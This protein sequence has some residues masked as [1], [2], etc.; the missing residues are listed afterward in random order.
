MLPVRRYLVTGSWTLAFVLTT[1]MAS[2]SCAVAPG[3]TIPL[4]TNGFG[5]FSLLV[6]D[7]TGLVAGAEAHEQRVHQG[8]EFVA[9]VP[10]RREVEIEWI[11]GACAHRPTLRVTGTAKALLLELSNAPEPQLPFVGCPAVGIPFAVTL[12]LT[13]P[14]ADGAAALNVTY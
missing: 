5:G 8:N 7:E 3:L 4:E 6:T 10:E 11:G 12:H 2:W 1:A 13:E 14:V 9:E